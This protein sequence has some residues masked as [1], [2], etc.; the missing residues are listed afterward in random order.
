MLEIN[1]AGRLGLGATMG[2]EIRQVDGRLINRE[3]GDYQISVS[4]V[5]LMRGGEQVWSGETVL[6]KSE[7]VSSLNERR[8]SKGR[9]AALS[10][11]LVLGVVAFAISRDLLG[12]GTEHSDSA[13]IDTTIVSNRGPRQAPPVRRIKFHGVF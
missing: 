13:T 6:I 9:T 8:F 7:Y 10:T 4:S 2:P 11:V 5:R 1:D 12:L 3:N